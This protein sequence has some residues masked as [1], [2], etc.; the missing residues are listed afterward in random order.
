VIDAC[1]V[2]YEKER[3]YKLQTLPMLHKSKG[4]NMQILQDEKKKGLKTCDAQTAENM[5]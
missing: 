5:Q 1:E 4:R 3:L 2:H